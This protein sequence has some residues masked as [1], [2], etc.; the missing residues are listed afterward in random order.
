MKVPARVLEVLGEMV[1]DTGHLRCRRGD[2][3]ARLPGV[4]E[5][6]V[7][8]ALQSLQARGVLTYRVERLARHEFWLD[9]QITTHDGKHA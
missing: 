3:N 1:D 5:S 9:V 7:R 4:N 8:Q 2:L 6:H